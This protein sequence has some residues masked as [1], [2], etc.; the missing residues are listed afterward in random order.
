MADRT[1]QVEYEIFK[2]ERT[3]PG[4]GPVFKSVR[5]EAEAITETE[6]LNESLTDEE[7]LR[8]VQAYYRLS[9][10]PTPKAAGRRNSAR[11][12]SETKAGKR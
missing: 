7:R 11:K 12:Y 8:G 10:Y 3:I 4:G 5:G 1:A 6:R 9:R 2:D